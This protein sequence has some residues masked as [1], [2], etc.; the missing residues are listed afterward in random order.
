VHGKWKRAAAGLT[1]PAG[2]FRIALSDPGTYRVT[3]AGIDAGTVRV[4]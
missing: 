1:T 3:V 4:R 2:D